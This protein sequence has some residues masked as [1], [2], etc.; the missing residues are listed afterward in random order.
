MA[1]GYRLKHMPTG[2]LSATVFVSATGALLHI[3]SVAPRTAGEY[4]TVL[5][6]LP[7][8]CGTDY[9]TRTVCCDRRLVG[10]AADLGFCPGCHDHAAV[11]LVCPTCADEMDPSPDIP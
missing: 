5:V 10:A 1:T 7:C 4:D 8:D 2:R 6:A 11:V 9:E 3:N